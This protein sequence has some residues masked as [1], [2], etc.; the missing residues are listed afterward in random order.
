MFRPILVCPLDQN[1]LILIHF[2]VSF[3]GVSGLYVY[4]I[5]Y[6]TTIENIKSNIIFLIKNISNK[7][8]ML[9]N[10]T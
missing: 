5:I 10:S 6:F 7:I 8:N 4:K 1:I 3:E 9:G 2:S